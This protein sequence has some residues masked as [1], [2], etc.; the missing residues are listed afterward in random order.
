M[1]PSRENKR[2]R[3]QLGAAK[4]EKI[5]LRAQRDDV[6]E[7]DSAVKLVIEYFGPQPPKA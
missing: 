6:E 5:L 1:D 7:E 3:A 2:I 4:K